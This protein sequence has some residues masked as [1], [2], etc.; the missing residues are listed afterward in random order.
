MGKEQRIDNV[1][2]YP[3]IL[4]GRGYPQRN[5]LPLEKRIRPRQRAEAGTKN[6]RILAG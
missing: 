2:D 1:R 6:V 5:P 4:L 3:R